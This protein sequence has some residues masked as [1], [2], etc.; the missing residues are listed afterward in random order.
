MITSSSDNI[1]VCVINL[2]L[3]TQMSSNIELSVLDASFLSSDFVIHTFLAIART[4]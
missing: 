3:V 2:L 1:F 4:I